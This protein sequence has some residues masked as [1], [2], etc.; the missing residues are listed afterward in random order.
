MYLLKLWCTT[1]FNF[2]TNWSFYLFVL[3]EFL[4]EISF[5]A[6]PILGCQTSVPKTYGMILLF[7]N[8]K[9]NF[10][11]FVDTLAKKV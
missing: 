4:F 8:E 5:E 9:K 7:G 6:F 11:I 1:L 3:T 2:S 10:E